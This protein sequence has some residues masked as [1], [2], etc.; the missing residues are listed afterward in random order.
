MQNWKLSL[1][2]LAT[3]ILGVAL[4]CS[5]ASAQIRTYY[6]AG[7]G[8]PVFPPSPVM[9]APPIVVAPPV[10]F[11]PPVP[12]VSTYRPV[13]PTYVAPASAYTTLRPV[14]PVVPAVPAPIYAPPAYGTV[15]RYRS[16]YLAPGL[17]GAPSVYT[18]GQ[19]VRNAIR[20]V[21]P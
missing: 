9:I 6:S 1:A 10:V 17:G 7:Y 19:P 14:Y 13:V 21:V 12:V 15:A 20:Y 8:V 11:T 16:G 3:A 4:S 18:P 5:T 2:T